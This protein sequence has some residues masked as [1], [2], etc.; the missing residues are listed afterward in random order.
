M[1]DIP[2]IYRTYSSK[3]KTRLGFKTYYAKKF[4][5]G[6]PQYG[7]EDQYTRMFYSKPLCLL[8]FQN[9]LAEKSEIKSILEVGCSTGMFLEEFSDFFSKKEYLGLDISQK[10]IELCRK[11]FNSNFVCADFLKYDFD[12]QY[13]LVYS[14]DVI[15]HVYDINGFMKKIVES[16]KK[17][18]YINA[19]RGYHKE[20]KTHKSTFR[21]T[22][23]IF[24]NDISIF[25]IKDNLIKSGLSKNE[26]NLKEVKKRDEII[27]D[28]DLVRSWIRSDLKNKIKLQEITGFSERFFQNIPSNLNLSTKIIS[29][30]KTKLTPEILGMPNSYYNI[31]SSSLVIEIF[32]N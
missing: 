21:D 7:Y 8:D 18:A 4:I 10:S 3:I 30:S 19:Y 17:F 32:K 27:Y 2:A 6:D 24:M 25:E 26:F 13:D 16:T 5:E 12:K 14:F 22:E 11:K 23:G 1:K 15:D 9:F 31:N 20:L 29:Q 28:G